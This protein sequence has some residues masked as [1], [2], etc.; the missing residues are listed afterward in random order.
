MIKK[1][2]LYEK[3]LEQNGR[4]VEYAGWN[5]PVNYAS[6]IIAEHNCVRNDVGM[7]DVSHM[8]EILVKGENATTFLESVLTNNITK[9][10]P[11]RVRYTIMCNEAGGCVDDLLVYCISKKEYFLVVNA[12]N[13][14][15]DYKWLKKLAKDTEIIDVSDKYCQLAVQGPNSTLALN[16]LCELPEK[17]FSFIKTNDLLISQTGYT[18]EQGYEIY[19]PTTAIIDMWQKLID[20]NVQP[21]GLGCRDTLRFEA[22]LPLYG[23]EIDETITPEEAGLQ[24]AIDWNKDFIGR[25]AMFQLV[26][27][28]TLIGLKITERGIARPNYPVFYGGVKVG[29]I[30]SGT[31]SPTFNEALACALI[32]K[33]YSHN[34]DFLVEIRGNKVQAVKVQLPFYERKAK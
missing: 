29:H 15:K 6:G 25:E 16:K 27:K 31:L 9:L 7:F 24:F 19:G 12:A 8:G 20:K 26:R 14:D 21:C 34:E 23:H 32:L 11:G 18:G 4:M 3:H 30:T 22:G 10:Q 17:Y 2:A 5:L 13:K 33:D 28:R 1:T